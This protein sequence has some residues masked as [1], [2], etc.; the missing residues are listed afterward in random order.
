MREQVNEKGRPEATRSQIFRHTVPDKTDPQRLDRY[1]TEVLPRLS[2]SQVHRLITQGLVRFGKQVLK[3]SHR[4]RPGELFQVEIPPPTPTSLKPEKLA[5]KILHQDKQLLV[6]DKPAGM[7]V[8][9]ALGHATGTLVNALLGLHLPLS[10]MAGTFKPGL[11]HRLDKETSGV[12]VVAKDDATH[13]N[14]SQ[15]FADRTVA[16]TYWA[17]VQGV[18]ASDEGTISAPI[19]RHPTNRQKMA[20]RY[21]STRDALTRYRVVKRFKNATVLELCPQTGRTHQLRVHLKHLGHPILGDLRYGIQA[22]FSRQ[23]L[24]AHRLGF[25]HPGKGKWVEFVSPLP[26]DLKQALE[27]FR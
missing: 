17:M 13:R 16:R 25:Q 7:V 19:G 18:V 5:L 6:V 20:V 4:V 24:H 27:R 26:T 23:A 3:A 2:R 1:L 10:S 22:G 21:D 11:V 14:I 12:L 9:P 15:Q 8:H